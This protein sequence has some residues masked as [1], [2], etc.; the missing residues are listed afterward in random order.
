[1]STRRSV[2]K[3]NKGGQGLK[4]NFAMR[5]SQ[6]ATAFLGASLVTSLLGWGM[7]ASGSVASA[8]DLKLKAPPPPLLESLDVHGF[9]DVT[10]LNDYITPR[11]LLVSNNGFATQILMGLVL[12]VYKDK[13]GFINDISFVG[14][15]WNDLWSNQHDPLVGPW[16]EFDWFVG[17]NVVFAQHWNF[18]VQYVEFVPPTPLSFPGTERNIEFSL[19]YDDTSWGWAVPFHPYAKL[20]YQFSGP[21]V[22]VLGDKGGSYDIE[23]GVVPT[24]DAKK[25]T[26]LP[27][28]WTAPTW[29]TVGPTNFWNRNDGTTNVCGSL[30]TSPC[31][32]SNAGVVTTGLQAKLGLDAIVPKRLGSWYVKAGARYYHI[33]NEALQAAQEFTG[34]T[35]HPTAVGFPNTH[36]NIGVF[37]GG[38]GFGF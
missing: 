27:L 20:F 12:D 14:G 6:F 37:Y 23:L 1:M 21:S 2:R 8:A 18:G 10:V 7:L 28:V 32:L 35:A 22:V 25:A 30:S 5:R 26:G 33:I 31:A 36:Q 38:I 29:V 11:G 15:T 3:F 9:V 19:N 34:T 16:N 4:E 17:G 13:S 24:Y